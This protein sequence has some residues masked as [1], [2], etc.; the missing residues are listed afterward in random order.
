M[1][2]KIDQVTAMALTGRMPKVVEPDTKQRSRRS[3]ARNMT[4]KVAFALVGLRHHDHGIP[5]RIGTNT[6]FHGMITGRPLLHVR[7]DC[8]DIGRLGSVRQV[9]T[10]PSSLVDKLF[11]QIMCSSRTLPLHDSLQRIQP[12]LR[13][14]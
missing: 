14:Q 2:L 6:L 1:S 8:I 11:K 13:F 12:F 7:W 4:T 9:G 5:A 3:E 10:R